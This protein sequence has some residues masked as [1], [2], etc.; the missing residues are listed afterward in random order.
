[1]AR[2]EQQQQQVTIA[3]RDHYPQDLLDRIRELEERV[4]EL[5]AK[6]NELS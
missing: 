6:V 1:M 5:E 4:R 2:I 3:E